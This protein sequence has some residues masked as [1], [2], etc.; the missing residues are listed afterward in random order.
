VVTASISI[1]LIVSELNIFSGYFKRNWPLVGPDAGFVTLGVTM[2]ILGVSILG[3]LNKEA[4]SQE[5][6]GLAFWRIV[7]ASGV[8]VI[9]VGAANIV[10][11]YVFREKRS[12]VTARHVRAHGAVA[13]EVVTRNSS[14]SSSYKSLH[15]GR[16][17]SLPTY[18]SRSSSPRST[19]TRLT[20]RLP[21]KIS[22]PI[23]ENHDQFAKFSGSPEITVPNLAHHPAMYSDRV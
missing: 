3:N 23:N 17:D 14:S 9:V 4:T 5:S 16:K 8:I 13:Q 7:I 19:S 1:F 2:I 10:L 22:S 20:P 12:G 15:L 21:L 18:H 6:L 11:S